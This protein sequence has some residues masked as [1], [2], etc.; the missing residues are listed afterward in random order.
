VDLQANETTYVK[1][2]HNDVVDIEYLV[3][4]HPFRP[5]PRRVPP[6]CAGLAADMLESSRFVFIVAI[7]IFASIESY[8]S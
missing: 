7:S 6:T 1:P 2:H 5:G 4:E 3:W 8:L